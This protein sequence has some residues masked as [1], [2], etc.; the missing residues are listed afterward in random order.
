MLGGT[1]AFGSYSALLPTLTVGIRLRGTASI[2]AAIQ[3]ESV[4]E[5]SNQ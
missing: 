3:R 5:D 4:Y 2:V 1:H